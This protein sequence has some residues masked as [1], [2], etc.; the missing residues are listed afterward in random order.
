MNKTKFFFEGIAL[1]KNKK[2]GVVIRKRLKITALKHYNNLISKFLFIT[3]HYYLLY[4]I[5]YYFIS[6]KYYI[7]NILLL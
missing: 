1:Q 5:I 4:I 7:N 2:M 3:V 6:N